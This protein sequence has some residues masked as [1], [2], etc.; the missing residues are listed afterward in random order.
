MTVAAVV[1]AR[2]KQ[3]KSAPT[4]GA[5]NGFAGMTLPA[6]SP[7]KFSQTTAILS[8]TVKIIALGYL[9]AGPL[10]GGF[11]QFANFGH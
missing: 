10:T 4:V 11:Q 3:G 7:G 5:S 2:A 1:V 9:Y 8:P 6:A